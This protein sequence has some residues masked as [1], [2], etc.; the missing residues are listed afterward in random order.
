[1]ETIIEKAKRYTAIGELMPE[2]LR[3]SIQRIEVG[4]R[5]K[6]YSRSASLSVRIIYRD[7]GVMDRPMEVK[8]M[9]PQQNFSLLFQNISDNIEKRLGGDLQNA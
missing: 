7:I 4:A 3:L 2:L 5:S 1:M 6:K 9:P 8:V